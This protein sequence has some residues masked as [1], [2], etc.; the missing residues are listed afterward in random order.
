[1]VQSHG[2][3]ALG[4]LFYLKLLVAATMLAMSV[5]VMA[6]AKKSAK[7][8]TPPPSYFETMG[9]TSGLLALVSVALAVMVFG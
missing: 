8:G 3:S 9:R 4:G 7:A 6:V 5:F 2:A 1:M